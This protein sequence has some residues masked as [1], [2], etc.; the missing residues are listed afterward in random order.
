MMTMIIGAA[1]GAA[2]AGAI[3]AM[4]TAIPAMATAHPATA[5]AHLATDTAHLATAMAHLATAMAHLAMDMVL[6]LMQLH[7]P[8][9]L[10]HLKQQLNKYSLKIRKHPFQGVSVS[11]S[12]NQRL[13]NSFLKQSD[14]KVS[15]RL[16]WALI[17]ACL[18]AIRIVPVQSGSHPIRSDPHHKGSAPDYSIPR[19]MA[20]RCAEPPATG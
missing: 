7:Q 4:D 16:A 1:L 13:P 6:I 12:N 20:L 3:P 14:T 10:P 5:M 8:Q 18:D 2:L 17:E 11:S 15:T 9:H 19:P